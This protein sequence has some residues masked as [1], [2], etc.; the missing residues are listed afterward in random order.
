MSDGAK[1]GLSQITS[2]ISEAVIK[3]ISDEVGK[4]LESASGSIMGGSS[5]PPKL[6]PKAQAQRKQQ[7]E[8]KKLQAMQVINNWQQKL[9]ADIAKVRQEKDQKEHQR[10]QVQQQ[11][12]KVKQYRVEEKKKQANA[13]LAAKNTTESRKGVGG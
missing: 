8:Q 9:E 4:A 5:S 11:E 3:P 13:A 10:L 7:D 12:E 2:D 6:D 1:S